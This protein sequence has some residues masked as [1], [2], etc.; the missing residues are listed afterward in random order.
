MGVETCDRKAR[1]AAQAGWDLRGQ[2]FVGVGWI[3]KVQIVESKRQEYLHNSWT[4]MEPEAALEPA[5]G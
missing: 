3:K 1:T 4:I 5:T 2:R